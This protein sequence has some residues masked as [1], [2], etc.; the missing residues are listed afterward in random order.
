[1]PF[2]IQNTRFSK[3]ENGKWKMGDGKI[4]DK[5]IAE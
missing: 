3:M 1:V 5:Q 4:E 2:F